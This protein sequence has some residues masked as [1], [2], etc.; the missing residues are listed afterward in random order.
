MGSIK[1]NAVNDVSIKMT[2]E[3]HI[4]NY[5]KDM[6]YPISPMSLIDREEQRPS[7]LCYIVE[8]D[9][10]LLLKRRKEP[11]QHHWTAP[12]GKIDEGETPLEA[13]KREIWEETG[14]TVY[15]P[16]LR[17]VC[18]EKGEADYN[19]LLFLFRARSYSG[20]LVE[21]DE[22]ELRWV[23]LD[24]LNDYTLPSIDRKIIPYV[25]G[26]DSQPYY[27]NVDYAPDHSVKTFQVKSL[28]DLV[29]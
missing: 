10:V 4:A 17:A 25:L 15:N 6:G 18:S 3:Q 9:R 20:E 11:F 26:D 7:T 21:S 22:G 8:E 12:G 28:A 1:Q 5:L 29:D 14:L 24:R 13:I 19:W 2:S 23:P 16:T 27:M